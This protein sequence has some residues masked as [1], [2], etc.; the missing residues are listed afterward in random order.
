MLGRGVELM[1]VTT[2]A[3]FLGP[4]V[5]TEGIQRYPENYRE[6]GPG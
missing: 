2:W 3:G 6:R 5:Y 4:A 1:W